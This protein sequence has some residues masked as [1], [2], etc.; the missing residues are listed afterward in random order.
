[1]QAGKTRVLSTAAA[2]AASLVLS[3]SA[4]AQTPQSGGIAI[5]ALNQDPQTV[6]PDV[7]SNVPDRLM[8]CILFQGM[9]QLTNDYK[10]MPL[11]AESW[12]ISPDGLTYSFT[13]KNVEWHDGKPLTSEDV[14]YTLTEVSPKY[15]AIFGP[16]GQ[17]ISSIE[18]PAKDKVVI[19][20]KESFGPFLISLGC[21]Q[22]AAILPSHLFQGTNPLQNPA[23]STAAVGTGAF[24]LAEWKRGDYVRLVANP[25]YHEPGKPYLEGV[26]GKVIPQSASQLQALQ[27]GEIDH[28]LLLPP[29]D[30]A[31]VRANPKLKVVENDIAP[32]MNFM[33]FNATKKPLDDK[34]V[35][36][37]LMR[38]TDRDYLL[39]NVFFDIGD[40]GVAPIT[41]QISWSANPGIDY[42]K[43]YP[44]DADKANAQLDEAGLKRGPD[45]KRF[46]ARITTF[47]TQYPELQQAAIAMKSMWQKVGVDVTVETLEDATIMKRVYQDRDFDITLISYTS[48]SDP[49][50]G[51]ARAYSAATI[52]RS[53]GNPSGYTDPKVETLFDQGKKA[54]AYEDRA[55]YYQEAQVTLAEDLPVIVLRQYRAVDAASQRLQGIWGKYQ[56]NGT[57][58]DAWLSN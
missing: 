24:K 30:R 44:Y 3:G 40:A 52:G 11:L 31:A 57:W 14:K 23:T 37:A 5:T 38:A 13:L 28:I 4:M 33:F 54:V 45:G 36:Q 32:S 6:N 29:A 16:A 26:V 27:A 39:K 21:N 47:A 58:T 1:M 56:G 10:M 48:Y 12:T 53:F 9:T 15:S 51:V 50:L 34:R 18:T 46:T 41:T 8:G 49:A 20:L 42:R 55:K 17:V 2:I 7:S 43:M 22:G 25:K 19:K 35:R